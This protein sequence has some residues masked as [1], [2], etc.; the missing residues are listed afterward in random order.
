MTVTVWTREFSADAA[1]RLLHKGGVMATLNPPVSP[2]EEPGWHPEPDHDATDTNC[3]GLGTNSPADERKE[4]D[5]I[6][7]ESPD[8]DVQD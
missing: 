6:K 4:Q 8:V 2:P 1:H 3:A 5:A 7:A